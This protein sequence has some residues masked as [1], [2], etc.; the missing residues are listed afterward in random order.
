MK[1]MKQTYYMIGM[2]ALFMMPTSCVKDELFNT[3]HP[4]KGAVVVKADFTGKST[5][6][7]VPVEYQL[8]HTCCGTEAPYSMP[9]AESEC[10]PGLFT[11]GNHIFHAWNNCEKMSVTDGTIKVDETSPGEVEPLPGYL[12]A[13]K[14][15]V[16]VI[17]DDTTRVNLQ[18][19]QHTRDLRVELTVTE[20]NPELIASVSGTLSGIAGTFSLAE[21]K[22]TGS[23][24]STVITFTRDGSR[25]TADA[26][27]LGI[28][29]TGQSLELEVRFTDRDDIHRVSVD[30][31]EALSGFNDDMT[32]TRKV[33]G[34]LETPIGMDVTATITGWKD[35]QGVPVVAE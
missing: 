13:A 10:F 29:G 4:D 8:R 19:A 32:T 2:A 34:D 26:R 18:M 25:I 23:A 12:F 33:T 16:N 1:T 30:L 6:A 22:I 9:S 27:L 17:Q 11:P 3:P 31:T 7:D 24:V 35:V 14:H 15:D 5:S 20:G 21:Q 28:I